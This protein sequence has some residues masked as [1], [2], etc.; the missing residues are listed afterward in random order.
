MT[1]TF[2]SSRRQLT[3]L[4]LSSQGIVSPAASPSDPAATVRRML[5]IQAQDFA[6]AKWSVGLRSPGTTDASIEAGL[7]AGE[8]VRSWPMRGTLHFVAPEDLG[9]ILSLTAERIIRSLAGR[10]RELGLTDDE[11][12]RA[13]DVAREQLSGGR[14]LTRDGL[15]GSFIAAGIPTTGQRGM[16]LLQRLCLDRLTV[17]GPV[18]GK[19]HTFVL[20][21]E[22]VRAPRTLERDEALGEFALRYFS[23]HG[24]AT[25]RDFAW[26]S[27]LTLTDARAGV[28]VARGLLD[29]LDVDGTAYYLRR[30]TPAAPSAAL[31]LAGFDEYLLGY[32]DRS[33]ALATQ[34]AALV[35]PG[36]NGLFL[37][38]IV[39]DGEVVGTW[40]RTIARGGVTVEARPFVALSARAR[41][42]FA[43]AVDDYTRF[44]GMPL[45][46]LRYG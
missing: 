28:A 45:Q 40:R 24:P 33:A 31:A 25:V 39:V 18:R 34:H 41:S 20:L 8:I 35:V 22:W 6:G 4:R 17:F 26:W 5:C 43:A 14:E 12:A 29:E 9:W 19:Q 16:H 21:E 3:A 36:A 10:E 13:G 42:R 7:A 23:G 44:V 15:L 32:Q 2:T 30:D 37:S 38:T 27:S 46:S 1:R 11:F